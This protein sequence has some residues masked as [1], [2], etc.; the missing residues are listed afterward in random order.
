P[1]APRFR[2]AA[3]GIMA[4][5]ALL[6]LLHGPCPSRYG[7]VHAQDPKDTRQQL[8]RFRYLA[9][10]RLIPQLWEANQVAQVRELLDRHRPDQ[11]GAVDLRGFEW[12]YWH[13]LC[14]DDLRTFRRHSNAITD[15]AFSPDGRRLASASG[16]ETVRIWDAATGKELHTLKG[17][18]YIVQGVA[19]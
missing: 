9:D 10:F 11:P 19:F 8:D 2:N 16:D 1:L 6:A 17:H 5:A 7:P 14:H 15:L 12:H 18:E 13:R 3:P 4:S